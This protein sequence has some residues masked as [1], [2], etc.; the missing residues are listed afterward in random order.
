MAADEL[1]LKIESKLKL[2]IERLTRLK[3]EGDGHLLR[4]ILAVFYTK[5]PG[6]AHP[7]DADGDR[8]DSVFAGYVLKN[9]TDPW[10]Q[11]FIL[12]PG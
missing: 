2:K 3:Q 1:V 10:V 6:R 8:D 5:K 11:K 9:P 12:G 4:D 7:R